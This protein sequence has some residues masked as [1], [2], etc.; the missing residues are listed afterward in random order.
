MAL[1][2][3][4]LQ[5][6]EEAWRTLKSR[7]PPAP[8]VSLGGAPHPRACGSL[9]VLSL[10]LERTPPEHACGDTLAQPPR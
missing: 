6:V 1:G 4:Q 3:K 8:G 10:L 7:T 5:R 2:Y 9:T